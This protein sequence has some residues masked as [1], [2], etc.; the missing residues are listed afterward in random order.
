MEQILIL[1]I[2]ASDKAFYEEIKQIL[3]KYA[4]I[5]EMDVEF[6][7]PIILAGLEIYPVRRKVYKDNRDVFLT[8]KEFNLLYLLALNSGKVLTYEQIYYRVWKADPIGNIN[9][10]IAYHICQIKKK[11]LDEKEDLAFDIICV[12]EIGYCFEEK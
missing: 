12:R 3:M 10:V 9:N 11:L 7:S 6:N 1:K 4:H 8:V 5:N 2:E